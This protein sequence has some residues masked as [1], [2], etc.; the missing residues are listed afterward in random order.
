MIVTCTIG[1]Y[2]V[3]YDLVHS[4][5][6]YWSY[7][8]IFAAC[9]TVDGDAM[10][11]QRCDSMD[12]HHKVCTPDEV[13]LYSL[14]DQVRIINLFFI[15]SCSSVCSSLFHLLHIWKITKVTVKFLF[16][17]N[18]LWKTVFGDSSRCHCWDGTLFCH[19]NQRLLIHCLLMIL[20]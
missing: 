3:T 13:S 20:K 5:H 2:F 11:L 4:C 1:S 7:V 19:M 12:N 6:Q 8:C 10:F 16:H 14:E 15:F 17:N 18:T 9:V